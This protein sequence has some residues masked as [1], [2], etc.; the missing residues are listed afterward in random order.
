MRGEVLLSVGLRRHAATAIVRPS[1]LDDGTEAHTCVL[2]ERH[3]FTG[4]LWTVSQ[5]NDTTAR[6]HRALAPSKTKRWQFSLRELIA[7][8]LIVA[9]A[10]GYSRERMLHQHAADRLEDILSM[11]HAYIW[12]TEP[13][14]K[15][16]T[17]ANIAVAGELFMRPRENIRVRIQ[18]IR[19]ETNASVLETDAIVH[20][21]DPGHYSFR[22]D[23]DYKGGL[24]PGTYLVAAKCFAADE[25]ITTGLGAIVAVDTR[26][27]K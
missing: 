9:L 6:P 5:A 3:P 10:L 8:T 11:P 27:P 1:W 17:R 24:D 14:E 22:G 25:L 26:K 12:S 15:Y 16:S 19:A 4:G 20:T 18:L 13:M 2:T 7:L 23:L 21:K